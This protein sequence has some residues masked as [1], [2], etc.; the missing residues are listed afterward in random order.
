[1]VFMTVDS[2][3]NTPVITPVRGEVIQSKNQTTLLKVVK[4]AA[5]ILAGVAAAGII[6]LLHM[7]IAFAV[8]SGFIVTAALYGYEKLDRYCSVLCSEDRRIVNCPEE[9]SVDSSVNH[10]PLFSAQ[11]VE[12][13]MQDIVL[14]ISQARD[15]KELIGNS[16]KITIPKIVNQDLIERFTEK[17]S[18][19]IYDEGE[20]C[21]YDSQNLEGSIKEK[22]ISFCNSE[23]NS[24]SRKKSLLFAT[25]I[26]GNAF[27]RHGLGLRLSNE[28]WKFPELMNIWRAT[29]KKTHAKITLLDQGFRVDELTY[30]MI[31]PQEAY[32]NPQTGEYNGFGE[33]IHLRIVV[34]NVKFIID[35][36]G[37]V[38]LML[39]DHSATFSMT[40]KENPTPQEHGLIETFYLA[41]KLIDC[42]SLPTDLGDDPIEI[43]APP[44][45]DLYQ[46]LRIPAEKTSPENNHVVIPSQSLVTNANQVP[47]FVFQQWDPIRVLTGFSHVSKSRKWF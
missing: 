11:E 23:K 33:L 5:Y 8:C 16:E 20:K 29:D 28:V 39:K 27:F 40:A 15:Q 13:V 7:P 10:P 22:I 6:A 4:V 17:T 19:V 32:L 42:R 9:E 45:E 3:Y 30:E 35:Q 34:K 18:V 12:Q 41:T 47:A 44:E 46:N 31:V 37:T 38:D 2:S 1:M 24:E 21:L 25:Q 36:D 14:G 26:I 43:L